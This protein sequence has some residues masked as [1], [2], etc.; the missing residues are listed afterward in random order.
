MLRRVACLSA[1][2][3]LSANRFKWRSRKNVCRTGRIER[4]TRRDRIYPISR[5]EQMERGNIMSSPDFES[6]KHL[7]PYAV[8][9]W[10]A[11]E[12]QPLLGY[13]NWREFEGAIE[14]AKTSCEATGNI[15]DD[16]FVSGYKL[17]EA[18]KGAKRPITDYTLSRLACYLIASAPV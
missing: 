9:Y 5:I 10:E 7:N 17:I 1:S 6:I 4:M 3:F 8:E 11:R 2:P 13:K 12:L 14:R 15:V 18:G 16:H